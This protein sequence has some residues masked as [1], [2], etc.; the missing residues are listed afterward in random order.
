MHRIS[1]VSYPVRATRKQILKQVLIKGGAAVVEEVPAP[2]VGRKSILVAVTDS[3]VSV[4]TESAGLQMSGMPL[5]RRAL[6]Q[7]ENVKRVLDM[8]RDQGVKR[9]LDRV[10]GKLAAGS[11]TGYSAAG[12]VVEVGAEVEGFAVGDR[13][14]CAGAGI[15]NHAELIDV[16]VNLA[17]RVPDEVS[18]EMASTVTLGAI[19]MQGVRRAAPTLGELVVVLGLGILGQ[20]TVQ[21]LKANGCRVIGTDLDPERV[22]LAKNAGMDHGFDPSTED[23]AEHVLRLSDGFGADAVIVTAASS[24]DQIISD[25]MRATRKKGRVVLVGDVGL[26]L[27]RA[28]FYAKELDF[29]ISTSYGPG[30]YDPVYEE[31]GADYPLPYVRWTENRNMQAYLEMMRSGGVDLSG[32]SIDRYPVERAGEAYAAL[33][34]EG[35]KPLIVFL[36]YPGDVAKASVRRVD[37]PMAS[38][39]RH[40]KIR[41]GLIGASSFAQGV[42]LPNMVK[43]RDQYELRAVMSRTGANAKA[44]AKQYEAAYCASDYD[45][46]LNDPEVDLIMVAT[47]HNLHAEIALRALQAGK[48]VFVEK[49]LAMTPTE[50]DAIEQFY[51]GSTGSA[52][53][54]MTGFNRRFAPAIV[55]AREVLAASSTPV[56]VNYRMNAGFIPRSHWVH[57]EEGGG[58]NIGE[59]CHIYDL[60]N[61]FCDGAGVVDVHARSVAPRGE[62]WGRNDNFVAT[63]TYANGSVCTLTYTALGAKSHPKERMDIY[64]DGKVVTMDDYKRLEIA[65][66]NLKGW[67]APA[68]Q[69]GQLEELQALA[70]CLTNGSAWPISLH[71]QLVATRVSFEV[72]RQIS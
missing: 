10:M 37:M 53:V 8:M 68:M 31:G 15:A 57:G 9:T 58:R 39:S 2:L 60:F 55:R 41:V 66:G 48:H 26:N 4:G 13:V 63:V 50:L 44:V 34:G 27:K 56:I 72:E 19:A 7:P 35:I 6:K 29:F 28:D 51:A 33:G 20:I 71:E 3:C 46:I 21:L 70:T 22:R 40:G 42:H 12:T 25:A 38:R 17:V 32:L 69:K 54:L 30:R 14:S 24:N 43:L 64:A 65:G 62:Q 23:F 61:L 49:P 11:A 67:S 1:G 36:A 5:Y 59:A 52:P 47:R 45:E 18:L 16:P